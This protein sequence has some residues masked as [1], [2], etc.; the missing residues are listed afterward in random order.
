[1]RAGEVSIAELLGGL[2]SADEPARL[3]AIDDLG[4]R[5][6]QAAEAVASLGELLQD[7]SAKVRAHAAWCLGAIGDA[8]KPA[9]PALAELLKDPDPAVRRQAVRAVQAIHPGPQ[10]VVPLCVKLLEDSDPAIR[11]R[12]LSA[13]AEA[14]AKAVPALIEA[15]KNDKA[16]YWACLVL[17]EIGPAAKDAVPA[18]AE[19]LKDPRPEIRREAVLTLGAMNDAA[20]AVIPQIAALLSDSHVRTAAT[21]VLGE[22]GQIPA[23][24]EAT[25]RANAKSDDK[26]LSTTSL[27]ALAR[28]HPE[29]KDLRRQLTEELIARLKDRDPFVRTA[30]ARAL[31]ALPPAPEIT[32]PLWEKALQGADYATMH[33]ALDALAALGAPAVPRL[34]DALKHEKLRAE[35]VYILGQIGPAAAPATSALVKLID[36]KN[37]RVAHEAVL[38]LGHIGPGAK[39]A[40]PGLLKILESGKDENLNFTAIAYS[41]GQIGPDAVAAQPALL[42]LLGNADRYLALVSAWALAHI[43]PAPAAIAAKTVPVLIEG[44]GLPLPQCRLSAAEALGRLGPLAKDAAAALQKAS[45]DVDDAVRDAAAKA[46]TAVQQ[47]AAKTESGAVKLI[48]RG[49]LVVTLEAGVAMMSEKSVVA[50]LPKAAQLKV[51]EVRAPWVAVQATIEGKPT[52]G[53]VLQTQIGK[54]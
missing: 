4:A 7:G 12:V 30:A 26:L 29:D 14:G 13:M 5:G 21:F 39:E 8:A 42:D 47:P 1:L 50:R 32:A 31:A 23:D 48:V 52:T 17:R 3:K 2:K 15:L 40:V 38:A 35:V 54:P 46:L 33:H 45:T 49:D 24:A 37:D 20:T 19:K 18:L 27:W 36:D 6:P 41:L 43:D 9:V 25:M 28:V 10:V 44:L 11:V 16:A 22:L 34:I 53:W 51:L